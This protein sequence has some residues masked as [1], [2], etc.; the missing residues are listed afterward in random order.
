MRWSAR[1]LTP[2][3]N[4]LPLTHQGSLH[5]ALLWLDHPLALV[6]VTARFGAHSIGVPNA[7]PDDALYYFDERPL[8]FAACGW[9]FR[10]PLVSL[11]HCKDRCEGW[12]II[13]VP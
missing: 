2:C 11:T 7:V 13:G 4:V 1:A 5:P 6:D 10:F 9:R 8:F 3:R 12:E